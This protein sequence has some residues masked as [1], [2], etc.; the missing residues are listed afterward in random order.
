MRDMKFVFAL[1]ILFLSPYAFASTAELDGNDLLHKCHYFFTEDGS[2]AKTNLDIL[3]EGFCAGYLSGVTD[4]ERM[5]KLVEGKSSKASHYC[6]P[7]EVT[8]GQVLRILKKWLD[9]NPNKLHE[10]ADLI[11]HFALLEAFACKGAK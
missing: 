3:D 8:N 5:W 9:D 7:E 6:M 10:R 1:T 2:R 4:I 11:I